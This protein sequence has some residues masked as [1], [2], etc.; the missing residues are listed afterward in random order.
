MVIQSYPNIYKF[1]HQTEKQVK[2][3]KI[4]ATLNVKHFA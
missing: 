4:I 3:V 1:K 2:Y